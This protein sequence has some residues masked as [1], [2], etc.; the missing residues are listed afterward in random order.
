MKVVEVRNG[1]N[2]FL[3]YGKNRPKS[4]PGAD[5]P[6]NQLYFRVANHFPSD[7]FDRHF[8][9]KI[10]LMNEISIFQLM[11]VENTIIWETFAAL[12]CG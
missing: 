1:L 6:R 5:Y 8:A 12:D 7:N 4:A 9:Y 2:V 11:H 3:L 10:F